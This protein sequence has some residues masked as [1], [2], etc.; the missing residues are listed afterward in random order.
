MF[1]G[2][3]SAIQNFFNWLINTVLGFFQFIGDFANWLITAIGNVLAVILGFFQ[4]I[5]DFF[6]FVIGLIGELIQIAALIVQIVFAFVLLLFGWMF[7]AIGLIAEFLSSFFSAPPEPLPG[8][9]QCITAPTN[10][11]LCAIWYM[12]D[13]T[14]FSSSAGGIIVTLI[15]VC[16]DIAVV[17]ILIRAV[18][19]FIAAG[20]TINA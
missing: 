11:D 1:D 5:I 4:I 8:W 9:P 16:I 15:I 3:F 12:T 17:W 7:Q 18:M 2:I 6:S 19:K 14:V 20:D 10:H 13:N